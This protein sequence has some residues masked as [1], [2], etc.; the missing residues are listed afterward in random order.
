VVDNLTIAPQIAILLVHP[1]ATPE[2][3]RWFT[4]RC[5]RRLSPQVNKM[6]SP[7][8]SWPRPHL[9]P[10]IHAVWKRE[11]AKPGTTAEIGLPEDVVRPHS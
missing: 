11:Y 1:Q 6:P 2:D 3:G 8:T 5:Q 9:F 10:A 7:N 4:S